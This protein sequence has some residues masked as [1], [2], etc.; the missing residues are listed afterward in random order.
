MIR[1]PR[2]PAILLFALLTVSAGCS[3]NNAVGFREHPAVTPKAHLDD[4]GAES[5]P[6]ETAYYGGYHERF[7]LGAPFDSGAWSEDEL[8]AASF[9][10]ASNI[11]FH[12]DSA[13]LTEGAKEVLRQ[14]AV[15]MKAFPQLHTLI[16]GHSDERGS[17]E[18]NMRLGKRRARSAYNYLISLGV[19]SSQLA[20]VSFGKRFP[21]V[22]GSNEDAWSRNRRNEFMVSRLP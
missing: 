21:A 5:A 19:P 1:S 10:H 18:Y 22:Q 11:Y 6:R 17:D 7:G 20:T 3:A 14:N 15:R 2:L 12:F 13:V 16:A 4:N 9:I 8:R